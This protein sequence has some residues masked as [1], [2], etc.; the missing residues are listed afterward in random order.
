MQC[1][2]LLKKQNAYFREIESQAIFSVKYSDKISE[3]FVLIV[4]QRIKETIRIFIY[5]YIYNTKSV[6]YC[7][8]YAS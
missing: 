8:K 1:N 3:S 6:F 2:L 4:S 7:Q 5:K